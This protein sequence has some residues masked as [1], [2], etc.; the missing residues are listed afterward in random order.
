MN[1]DPFF[2]RP[3]EDDNSHVALFLFTAVGFTSFGYLL[4]TAVQ[5]FSS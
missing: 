5:I 4:A 1:R 3:A 2:D